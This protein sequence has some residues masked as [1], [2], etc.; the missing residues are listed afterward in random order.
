MKYKYALTIAWLVVCFSITTS[1][2]SQ[3]VTLLNETFSSSSFATNSW[4]FPGG[5]SLWTINSFYT[6]T[7]AVAPNAIFFASSTLTN[8]TVPLVSNTLN[9]TGITGPV[10]FNCLLRLQNS[11]SNPTGNERMSIEYKT[12]A[13]A[14]WSTVATFSNNVPGNNQNFSVQNFIL[15]GV[16]G[17]NF[18]VRFVAHGVNTTHMAGG[19]GLDNIHVF[20]VT[21]P[22]SLPA[23]T[24]SPTGTICSGVTVTLSASGGGPSFTWSPAGGHSPSTTVSPTVTTTYALISSYPG[25]TTTPVNALVTVTVVPNTTTLSS[26]GS[27]SLICEGSSITLSA[28]GSDTYTWYP[29]AS[30]GATL[31]V[32]PSVTTLYTVTSTNTLGCQNTTTLSIIVNPAP[33]L[34]VFASSPGICQAGTLSLIA[35]G[36]DTYSWSHG[37]GGAIIS[38]SPSVTT[39]Y[40]V[41][42]LNT[43][44]CSATTSITVH[45]SIPVSLSSPTS[46]ICAG[47]HATLT[48]TG[49][50]TYTW[51]GLGQGASVTASPAS[52]TIYTVQATDL[53]G[54]VSSGTLLL[55]VEQLP[56]VTVSAPSGT[57]CPGDTFTLSASG[58][59][60]Y[61]WTGALST[62]TGSSVTGLAQNS[63]SY[64]VTGFS[65]SG[66][67]GPGSSATITVPVGQSP[68]LSVSAS[69][70]LFCSGSSA[71]L[72]ATGADTYT[73]SHGVQNASVVISPTG[74][75]V[76]SVS[77]GVAS[78]QCLSTGTIMIQVD[79]SPSLQVAA[80]AT[81][82]CQGASVTLLANGASTYTWNNGSQLNIQY[83]T[84]SVTTVYSVSAGSAN[85]CLSHET[86]TV[87]VIPN[88]TLI[89]SSQAYTLCSGESVTCTATGADQYEWS[90]GQSGTVAVLAPVSST[91]YTLI[92]RNAQLCS[93]TITVA[94]LVRSRPDLTF[95]GVRPDACPG[96]TVILKGSGALTYTWSTGS[97]DSLITFMADTTTMVYTLSGSSS[98]GCTATRSYTQ[99]T[100]LCTGLN[101]YHEASVTLYPNPFR[102]MIHLSLD[103]MKA[104]FRL[105]VYNASG[106]LV[107]SRNSDDTDLWIDTH[108]LAKGLYYFRVSGNGYYKTFKMIRE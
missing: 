5:Q 77:A 91:T 58:A 43:S 30:A 81:M 39:T 97:N 29:G 101:E 9:A 90:S 66:C 35:S 21:C 10:F 22:A 84:P 7:A 59:A 16:T 75:G 79:P 89:T 28:S 69:Q 44:G 105:D 64:Q 18:Q 80:S 96:D 94:I 32:S 71:T 11:T 98:N 104:G 61:S 14:T 34:A 106:Q 6:P 41:T 102:D 19:W 67:T 62:N 38:V 48:A 52:T 50:D 86:L 92:G 72:Q 36:A 74:S 65:N 15:N 24:I 23:L 99:T 68:P 31:A 108:D 103:R 100:H 60:S 83:H 53:I 54:C 107:L 49:A 78:L 85:N 88:P 42:G 40:S 2:R 87:Q 20:G 46:Q 4:N 73:W 33:P 93:D 37:T 13:S 55:T 8:Y 82:I 12:T 51:S 1:L 17:Q 70:T 27:S 3:T 45:V 63:A 95:T 56:A 26:S 57:I 25:C 76:F 47:D